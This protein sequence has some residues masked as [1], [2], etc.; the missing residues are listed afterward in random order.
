[1]GM[2]TEFYFRANIAPGTVAEWLHGEINDGG[3]FESGFDEHPFFK[4]SRWSS[5]FIGG[6]SVSQES[7]RPIF[8]RKAEGGGE[9]YHHQLVLASSLKDYGDEIDQ[10]VE[11][12]GPHLDMHAGDFLGYKLY[13]DT[14]D[15]SD[16]YREHPTLFFHMRDAIYSEVDPADPIRRLIKRG[17][18]VSRHDAGLT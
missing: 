9:P 14:C 5:V 1:M 12:I 15:D 7:R 10:F 3:W 8:R 16:Q 6:G 4:C 13:E 18:R 2:Y 17:V 11:W